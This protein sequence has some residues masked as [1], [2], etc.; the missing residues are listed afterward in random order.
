MSTDIIA[1]LSHGLIE[2][3]DA[4]GGGGVIITPEPF[5]EHWIRW[6]FASV[7]KHFEG[8]K[9]SLG[10]YV[11]GEYKDTNTAS[12]G[13]ELRLDGPQITA[14]SGGDY[15]LEVEVN[16]LIKTFVA[17]SAHQHQVDLGIGLMGYTKCIPVYAYGSG[18]EDTGALIGLLQLKAQSGRRDVEIT[19][20]GQMDS[21]IN[22][23]QSTIDAAYTITLEGESDD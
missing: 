5:S 13:L 3:A 23:Q 17:G 1:F 10:F 6:I 22:L 2:E 8:Y 11:E 12:S 15:R 7:A 21:R 18:I 4:G 19:Q 9:Q 14:Q 16:L 20:F